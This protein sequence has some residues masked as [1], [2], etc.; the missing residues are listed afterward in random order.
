MTHDFLKLKSYRF[1]LS[2]ETRYIIKR[3]ISRRRSRTQYIK[4]CSWYI[5]TFQTAKLCFTTFE[6][7]ANAKCL[8]VVF[9]ICTRSLISH[10]VA[11]HSKLL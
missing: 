5:H 2:A 3:K 9:D 6:R 4:N 10:A 8:T 11:N 7:F 1:S